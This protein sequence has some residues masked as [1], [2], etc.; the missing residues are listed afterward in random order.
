MSLYTDPSVNI[1]R[2]VPHPQEAGGA[3]T[4]SYCRYKHFVKS[5]LKEVRALVTTAGTTTGH[6][7]DIYKGTTSIGS[8]S[9]GTSAAGSWADAS[10]TDTDLV[11]TD[12]ISVKTGADATGKALVFYQLADLPG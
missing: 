4:T 12:V 7:L 9:L 3:G 10:L 5:R 6:K 2:V 1:D 11:A 8:I